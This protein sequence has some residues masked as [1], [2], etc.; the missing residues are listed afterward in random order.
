VGFNQEDEFNTEI[1]VNTN[2]VVFAQ[3][4]VIQVDY[5]ADSIKNSIQLTIP[6]G[7]TSAVYPLS[8]VLDLTING[9]TVISGPSNVADYGVDSKRELIECS[10]VNKEK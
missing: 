5:T 9:Y 3:N 1:Y 8:N 7:S 6:A 10:I 2:N 4:V